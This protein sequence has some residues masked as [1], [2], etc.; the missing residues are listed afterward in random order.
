MSNSY[1]DQCSQY[2]SVYRRS[3]G[4]TTRSS[5]Y[6]RSSSVYRLGARIT[7]R[8]STFVLGLQATITPHNY[9]SVPHNVGIT[10][11]NVSSRDLVERLLR[12]QDVEDNLNGGSS[13]NWGDSQVASELFDDQEEDAILFGYFKTR[14]HRVV[15]GVNN[16]TETKEICAICQAEFEHEESIGTLGCGH[17]YHTGCIKQWLLRKKDC[18]M[19]RASVLP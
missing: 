7:T 11:A 3:V 2:T 1:Y 16:Q 19:C 15:E 8:Q 18:P 13:Q 17:E 10:I 9:Q 5:P 12:R 14:I 4:I 6:D